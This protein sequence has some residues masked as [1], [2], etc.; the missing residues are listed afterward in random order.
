MKR[1]DS[2]KFRQ[3]GGPIA[4]KPAIWYNGFAEKQE[5]ERIYGCF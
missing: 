3:K 4:T 1:H 5:R 2:E